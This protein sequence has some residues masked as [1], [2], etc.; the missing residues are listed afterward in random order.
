MSGS[1]PYLI[2]A[3]FVEIVLEKEVNSVKLD[4]W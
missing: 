1:S 2:K 4:V 3:I